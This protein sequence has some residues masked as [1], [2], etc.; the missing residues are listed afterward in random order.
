MICKHTFPLSG[1]F[2]VTPVRN[3]TLESERDFAYRA[4]MSFIGHVPGSTLNDLVRA[5]LTPTDLFYRD[6]PEH[7]Q[8][9]ERADWLYTRTFLLPPEIKEEERAQAVLVFERLDTYAAITLNGIPIGETDNGYIEHSFPVGHALTAGENTLEVHLKSPLAF[10]QGKPKLEGAFTTER[11]YTRRMQCT[12]GWDWTMRFVTTGIGETY[13]TFPAPGVALQDIYIYTSALDDDGAALGIDV[14]LAETSGEGVLDFVIIGEDGTELRR[15]SRFCREH[16]F[17]LHLDIAAPALW[18]PRGYGKQPLYTLC[19]RQGGRLLAC[20]EFGIRTLRILEL[21][22]EPGSP[23]A[24]RA[25][26]LKRSPHSAEYNKNESSS[27]FILKVNGERIL[28]QGA[29]WVPLSPFETEGLEEKITRVLE[30]AASAGVNFIRVWGGGQIERPHFYRECSRLGI[31]V[32]QDF[33]MACGAYPEKEEWFIRALGREADYA[34]R[35]LR[36]HPCLAW[37]HGD[38]EN[39]VNGSDLDRDYRGRDSAYRGLAPSVL[40]LDPYRRFLPSSPFGGATY[41]SNTAGTTHNT[42]YL[43]YIFPYYETSDLSDFKE[44]LEDFSARFISEEPIFGAASHAAL[45]RMMSDADIFEPPLTMWKYHTQGNPALSRDLFDYY[46]DIA[47]K[48]FGA[49]RD[50]ADRLF[51]LQ[52]LQCELTRLTLERTRRDRWFCAGM[53]YWMLA[54]C[55]PAASGWSLIDFYG[56]PKPALYTFRRTASELS[57]SLSRRGSSLA[58]VIDSIAREAKN[59]T[60]SVYRIREESAHLLSRSEVLISAGG[61]F[62]TSCP[63]PGADELTVAELAYDGKMIRTHYRT[64]TFPLVRAD[65]DAYT[66]TPTD[67][68]VTI[69]AA[70]YLQAVAIDPPAYAHPSDNYFSLLPGESIRIRTTTPVSPAD[71][72]AYEPLFH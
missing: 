45:L 47:Q 21:P 55:W 56:E 44:Y 31:L 27:G 14:T 35:V 50:G 68:G 40:A 13:L 41:A 25:E 52:Y 60:L 61:K 20:E 12:Y 43:S 32:A 53:V 30:L 49:F 57:P 63:L 46:H 23:F 39:A 11:L 29:N 10:P 38:N 5:G 26:E 3:M 54:D 48:L 64:G 62:E 36:N 18:Y 51:K 42:Q 15:I 34:V 70:R 22:D 72:T 6:N 9:F 71:I 58:L 66:V 1:D 16:F 67:D 19:I 24:R 17:R 8:K 59:I 33:F 4:D 37:W 65:A 28:A 7:V 2:H 69:T